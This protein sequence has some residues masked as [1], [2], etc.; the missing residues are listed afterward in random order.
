M[1]IW[2]TADADVSVESGSVYDFFA[3]WSNINKI[4]TSKPKRQN[5]CFK[6]QRIWIWIGIGVIFH[7]C[8]T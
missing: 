3:I 1:N 7:W 4:F 8:K 5:L 6:S 2:V